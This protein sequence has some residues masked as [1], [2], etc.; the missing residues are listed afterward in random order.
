MS[1]MRSTRKLRKS[2][3]SSHHAA[4]V[5]TASQKNTPQRP[6]A[7][8]AAH[9]VQAVVVERQHAARFERLAQHLQA[10]AR[11]EVDAGDVDRIHRHALGGR[12]CRRRQHGEDLGQ[13][14]VGVA[15][16][17]GVQPRLRQPRAGDECFGFAGAEHQRRQVE[18]GAHAV[19][20]A[21]FAFDRHALLLQV[22]DIAVHRAQRDL[23]TLGQP[24]GGGEPAPAHQLHQL[25]QTVGTSHAAMV[26]RSGGAGPPQAADPPGDASVVSKGVSGQF[27]ACRPTMLPSVSL[28]CAQ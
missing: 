11:G 1:T 23:E 28:M 27:I 9:V 22:G 5:H 12:A 25:E 24:L 4:S 3:R 21:G 20:D 15:R 17:R 16:Q 19:A 13:R 2:L 26:G 18:A 8:L 14:A 10:L 7:A 6:H